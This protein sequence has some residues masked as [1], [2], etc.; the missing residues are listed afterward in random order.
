MLKM[1]S[2]RKVKICCSNNN[3]SITKSTSELTFSDIMGSLKARW[4]INRMNFKVNPGLYSLG[5]PDSN[6]P[7]MVTGNYK[8]SFDA[9]RKELTGINSY[10][11]VLDTKGVN[12]WCAASKGTFGTNELMN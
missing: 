11:L 4:G 1:N 12:V 8:M 5:T 6:S 9:L 10:I 3:I 7:V 2:N